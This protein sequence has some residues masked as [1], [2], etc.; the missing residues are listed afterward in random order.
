MDK[1]IIASVDT[2]VVIDSNDADKEG[3]ATVESGYKNGRMVLSFHNLKGKT[4]TPFSIGATFETVTQMVISEGV[5]K[6]TF[7][8][9]SEGGDR[10]KLYQKTKEA[11]EADS[12]TFIA[13]LQ[14]LKGE[15]GD[16]IVG[17]T[18][19][20]QEDDTGV[21]GAVA[22]LQ[23]NDGINDKTLNIVFKNIKGDKGDI[24]EKGEPFK[25]ERVFESVGDLKSE[26]QN[27]PLNA[28]ALID[29]HNAGYI[30]HGDLY[31]VVTNDYGNKE[32]VFV[33][34][35][36]GSK[37]DTGA[38]G[39]AGSKGEQGE[40]GSNTEG[41]TD[42]RVYNK[43]K[44]HCVHLTSQTITYELGASREELLFE[45]NADGTQ[46]LPLM[47]YVFD[48]DGAPVMENDL[49]DNGQAIPLTTTDD[50]G[51]IVPLLDDEG[52]TLY[53]QHQKQ[54]QQTKTVIDWTVADEFVKKSEVATVMHLVGVTTTALTDG[55][56]TPAG[57]VVIGGASITDFVAGDTLLCGNDEW[58]FGGDDKWHLF[59]N[60][61][62]YATKA[63]LQSAI[64]SIP[65][66]TSVKG[67]A[68]TVYRIGQVNLTAENIG[69]AAA[70]H[71]HSQ[72]ISS[73]TTS[74][75]SIQGALTI[76]A[77][78][79][80]SSYSRLNLNSTNVALYQGSDNILHLH[81]TSGIKCED[82]LFAQNALIAPTSSNTTNG[83]I[84]IS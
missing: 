62:A 28:Y 81:G 82:T 51:N 39:E 60:T 47:E 74:I 63:E 7:I 46:G 17:A 45:V 77:N 22:T 49:D 41:T 16:S 59:G 9:I 42:T 57:G 13:N 29:S 53:Q 84:W 4:G 75:Q 76:G 21:A 1:V 67:N 11:D 55:E 71:T 44:T 12:Y 68:E 31:Q 65:P 69:A 5:A 80:G 37:G 38:K 48:E 73:N 72:Y 15:R 32:A 50:D 40:A 43:E 8:I 18:V 25:I 19:T 78:G 23:D 6:D 58:V 54:R 10:G 27:L 26:E 24:G 33:A 34:N 14:G 83:A 79:A 36:A 70:D 52:N 61:S 64:T 56:A 3:V 30:S 20:M 2:P 35:I 66:G